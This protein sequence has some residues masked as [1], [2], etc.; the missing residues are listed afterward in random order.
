MRGISMLSFVLFPLISTPTVF[1]SEQQPFEYGAMSAPQYTLPPLPYAYD[2]S[3]TS[4]DQIASAY[5]ILTNHRRWSRTSP[6]R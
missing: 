5:V 4:D 2:V 3:I 1:A 6:P